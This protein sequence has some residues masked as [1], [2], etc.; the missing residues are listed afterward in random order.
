MPK[1]E[2][3]LGER[4]ELDDGIRAKLTDTP[5]PDTRRGGPKPQRGGPRKFR[6]KGEDGDDRGGFGG[7][8]GKPYRPEGGAPKGKGPAKYK[9][10]PGGK[11]GAKPG[12]KPGAARK[13]PA[14]APGTGNAPP[15]RKPS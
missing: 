13:R 9:A 12:S 6:G 15:R 3:A 8:P 2:A 11:P 5:P 1:V 7:K 4:G 10:N 14:G